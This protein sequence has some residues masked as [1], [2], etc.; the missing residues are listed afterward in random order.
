MHDAKL[1]TIFS[2]VFD[3]NGLNNVIQQ[4]NDFGGWLLIMEYW[5]YTSIFIIQV[6]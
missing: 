4:D 5:L 6:I 2:H 3:A 1:E